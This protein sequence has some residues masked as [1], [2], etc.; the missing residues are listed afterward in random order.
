MRGKGS[1]VCV[2]AVLWG[3]TALAETALEAVGAADRKFEEA[4]NR[5]DA[6]A[7]AAMYTPD[8][9]VLPPG[10]ARADGREAIERFWRGAIDAGAG[11]IAL[12]PEEVVEAGDLAYEV[13][14]ATLKPR[15]GGAPPASVKY[16]VVW[17]RGQDGVWR[18]HRDVWN[19]NPVAAG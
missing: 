16:V 12:R 2:A 4:F 1:V 8:G 9:A 10:A 3:G 18:L 14:S 11:E 6:A 13:G 7:V 17:R 19:L 15:A 5:G